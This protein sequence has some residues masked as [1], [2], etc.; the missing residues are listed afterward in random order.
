M[1]FLK[2]IKQGL[3]IGTLKVELQVP[4]QLAKTDQQIQGQVVLTA[5]SEQKIKSIK[6]RM[7]E[8]YTTGHGEEQKTK[9][10]ELGALVM[11]T[12]FEMQGEETKTIDFTLPFRM[13]LSSNQ[14]LAEEKGALGAL[15][16]AAVFA[17]GEKSEYRVTVTVD[18]EGV[19]LDPSDDKEIR[20]V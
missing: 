3:G 14:S 1:G 18:L 16:K 15:G 19:A 8:R 9:D 4:G 6:F 17:K 20:L 2:K 5:K 7:V 10:Y 11:D 12:A 13:A